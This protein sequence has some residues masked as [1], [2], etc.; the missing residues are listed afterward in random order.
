MTDIADKPAP[1]IAHKARQ[2]PWPAWQWFG[3]RLAR[4]ARRAL[5]LAIG[6]LLLGL[7]VLLLAVRL[8]PFPF[9]RLNEWPQSPVI[10]D[11]HGRVMLARCG[12]DEQWRLPDALSDMSPWLIKATIAVEDERFY[13]HPGVDP[14][15]VVRAMGQNI[16]SGRVVSG[17]STLTMQVCRMM[18]DRPR[19]LRAKA[20]E[21]F[22]ALQLDSRWSKDR[23]LQTYLNIAPYGGN[24][25]GVEAAAW[26]YFAK[27]APD[28]SLG[29]AA[30][31]AGRP[32]SPSRYRPDAHLDRALARRTTVLRR[33]V[34]QGM[35]SL[36]DYDRVRNEPIQ[37]RQTAWPLR[38][39]H[40]AWHAL[41]CRPSGGR[42]TIDLALH[43]LVDRLARRHVA[44]LP[45]RSSIA[46]VIIDVEAAALRAM[47]TISNPARPFDHQVNPATAPRSPGSTLKPFIYAAAFE[48]HR[49]NADS[50]VYDTPIH[51]A[52]WSPSNFD[53]RFRGPV[54]VDHALRQ[55][56][57]IP[58][59]LVAEAIGID[60]CAGLMRRVGLSLPAGV[61]QRGGL[62]VV[63]GSVETTLLDL[64]NAY[65]TFARQGR[66]MPLRLF[67]D[68]ATTS[69]HA[70]GPDAC[71]TINAILDHAE[72]SP[73]GQ[74]PLADPAR[75]WYMFKTGTS[76]GRRD[77][78]A[79]GHN[80]RYAIG[81]WVGRRS[82]SG[83]GRYTGATAAAPLL[84]ELFEHELLV[85][86]VTPP[87][88]PTWPVTRPIGPPTKQR[89]PLRIAFPEPGACYLLADRTMTIHPKLANDR[90]VTWLING[91][92][93]EAADTDPPR[94]DLPIGVHELRA[95]DGNSNVA[96]V[97]FAITRQA[98]PG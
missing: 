86:Q 75:P 48:Q 41:A 94:L 36:A 88:C 79:I 62:A 49:L 97:R 87:S 46:V 3:E 11:R 38:A 90:P 65:A 58:A 25:R 98:G 57:N 5:G 56:L 93:L 70:L 51:R 63:V 74:S 91:R 19:T 8:V 33:M 43:Q 66:Y 14:V 15:A 27:Q 7:V 16:A 39:P 2:F 73:S 71:A 83:D 42:T 30:R 34:E 59:I 26:F 81:V 23:I 21:S 76:S 52:G 61:K 28:L 37:L 85:R 64:T 89:Q 17:A 6:L 72:P 92:L 18:D 77:A 53:G 45:M 24:V 9:N 95:V 68:D 78:W 50:L 32:H 29:E 4:F 54:T 22:R 13:Q 69:H 20:I 1:A 67:E 82:G 35:I 44:T 55:S 60:Q 84:A 31:L 12:A 10:T 80:G 47:T 96:V 40:A